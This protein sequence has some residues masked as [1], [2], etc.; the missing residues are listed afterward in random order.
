[1]RSILLKSSNKHD[2]QVSLFVYST[3]L[4]FLVRT[5]G[6]YTYC[7]IFGL[8]HCV[9]SKISSHVRWHLSFIDLLAHAV[10]MLLAGSPCALYVHLSSSKAI[11]N[12]FCQKYI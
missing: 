7:C 12:Q 1:M 4:M 5:L 10:H 8:L 2:I 9:V 6:I 3:G 11:G